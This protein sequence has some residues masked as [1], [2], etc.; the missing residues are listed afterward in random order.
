MLLF[1]KPVVLWTAFAIAVFGLLAVYV[2]WIYQ[3]YWEFQGVPIAF[4]G[5]IWAAFALTVSIAA[6]YASALEQRLGTRRLL[7]L[8]GASCR[9]WDCSVWRWAP[10]G[11]V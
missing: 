8:I 3:K 11:W 10:A 6:R 7:C 4:N 2:F 1:G 5:Y 9:C